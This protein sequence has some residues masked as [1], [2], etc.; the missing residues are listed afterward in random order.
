MLRGKTG[1]SMSRIINTRSKKHHVMMKK[2]EAKKQKRATL[3]LKCGS[4]DR[5]FCKKYN[6]WCT[7]VNYI[8]AGEK[9]PYEY[10]MPT[11]K[12]SINKQ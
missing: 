1:T 4:N 11:I 7:K 2:T 3:C 6:N 8:C 10:K 12:D 5:G 9:N